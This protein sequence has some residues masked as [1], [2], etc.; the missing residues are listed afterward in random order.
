MEA[1]FHIHLN[2]FPGPNRLNRVVASG[3]IHCVKVCKGASFVSHLPFVNDS[4]FFFKATTSG[5]K[6]MMAIF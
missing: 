1:L 6:T 2:K 3:T 5:Y 4:F